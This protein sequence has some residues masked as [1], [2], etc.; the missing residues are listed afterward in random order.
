MTQTYTPPATSVTVTV[1]G[2]SVTVSEKPESRAFNNKGGDFVYLVVGT[3]DQ[4]DAMAAVV[5]ASPTTSGVF[6]RC[7]VSVDPT[8][9]A[10]AF[11]A[12]ATY[13]LPGTKP[14]KKGQVQPTDSG[15]DFEF[16]VGMDSWHV[17][18]SIG[19]VHSYCVGQ[20]TAPNF[21][22]A[23]NV[24]RDHDG[25]W[26]VEGTTLGTTAGAIVFS[27][28]YAFTANQITNAYVRRLASMVWNINQAAFRGF[29]E[30]EVAFVG[31]RGQKRGDGNWEVTFKYA[32]ILG[33]TGETDNGTIDIGEITGISKLGWYYLWVYYKLFVDDN[34]FVMK[35]PWAVYIEQVYF[36]DDFGK[37]LPG[38]TAPPPPG[39]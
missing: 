17:T 35:K 30:G 9:R 5:Q 13:S 15:P 26:T 22:T 25:N 29:A 31:A 23:M 10:D 11:T 18:S 2:A 32:A 28:T 8:L 24:S 16:E 38:W 39:P 6:G 3:E 27:E 33:N 37:L 21:H 19:T 36:E 14:P 4:N 7:G 1:N 20:N 34:G 12:T